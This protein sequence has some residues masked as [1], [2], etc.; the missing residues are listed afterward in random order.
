MEWETIDRSKVL[1]HLMEE[2]S[3]CSMCGTAEWE[4]DE[5]KFAYEPVQT[6]CR[7]CYLK[8]IASET[9]QNLPGVTVVLLPEGQ[10]TDEMRRGGRY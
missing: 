5:N 6:M 8:D 10:V 7:G 4:W 1:A 9:E 3:K 2:A